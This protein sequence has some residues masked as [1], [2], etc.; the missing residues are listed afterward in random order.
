[1]L[2]ERSR[3]ERS[4]HVDIEI[5]KN[6]KSNVGDS[7]SEPRAKALLIIRTLSPKS[8]QKHHE[9]WFKG[10]KATE[11]KLA[12]QEFQREKSSFMIRESG[13]G[14]LRG[15]KNLMIMNQKETGK[16]KKKCTI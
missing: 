16:G 3:K 4:I 13:G 5:A 7:G 1:M 11:E 6:Y 10:H 12:H 8:N 14:G 9:T 2:Q 15:R